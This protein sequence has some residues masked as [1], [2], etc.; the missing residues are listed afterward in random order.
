[1]K[2]EEFYLSFSTFTL[3]V[4]YCILQC[5]WFASLK[6]RKI[7]YLS[8]VTMH[9]SVAHVLEDAKA[10]LFAD[11]VVTLKSTNHETLQNH[12]QDTLTNRCVLIDTIS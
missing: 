1:M 11:I 12:Y 6:G 2:C 5:M 3:I 9:S 8:R 10:V 4:F 7:I